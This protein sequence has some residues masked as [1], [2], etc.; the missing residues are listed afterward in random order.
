[1]TIVGAHALFPWG[2]NCLSFFLFCSFQ[3]YTIIAYLQVKF[4]FV[5]LLGILKYSIPVTLD[6]PLRTVTQMTLL[7]FLPLEANTFSLPF[8]STWLLL[9]NALTFA[10]SFPYMEWIRRALI[11]A[12]HHFPSTCSATAISTSITTTFSSFS[13]SSGHVSPALQRH[14]QPPLG[15][16]S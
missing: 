4:L 11:F 9:N 16:C 6:S 15:Y 13:V 5:S 3:V 14:L 10:P 2:V 12:H 7:S 1:M 8:A